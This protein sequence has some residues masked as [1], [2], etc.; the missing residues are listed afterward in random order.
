MFEALNAAYGHQCLHRKT[1]KFWFDAFV[2]GRTRIVDQDR[3]PKCRTGR[4]LANIQIIQRAIE[5]DRTLT[6]AT[7]HQQTKIPVH[8]I[9]RILTKDL[10]LRRR[11]A[12]MVPASL[13]PNHLRQ[14]LECAQLMLCHL[15]RNAAVIKKIV[16][17]DETWV[18]MYDPESKVQS[19]QWLA[20]GDARP[21]KPKM[22]RAI[23]KCMLL[24]FCD[25]KGM[26]YHE[27]VHG[28]TINTALFIQIL[29]RFQQAMN[30][31]RPGR[32][33]RYYL[34]MDNASPHTSR[35]TCLHLL[36]T[37]L[38]VLIHP[39][40]SPDLAPSDFWLYPRLK[41]GLKGRWFANLDDLEDAV[42]EEIANISSHEYTECFTHKWPMRWARCVFH[43][44]DYFKGL[45]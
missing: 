3:D 8:S 22:P 10:Q 18:Y 24:T 17:M 31:K 38:R 2:N 14:R 27:F 43:D 25:W 19:S 6:L 20:K 44:R 7:L 35:D 1:V 26:V 37:G 29:G 30:R 42:D 5:A 40:Y 9:H 45:S 21:T 16:T 13:T 12:R 32:H 34:H 15:R 28:Q 11:C 33:G 41:H 23:G 36:F 39:P 4:S